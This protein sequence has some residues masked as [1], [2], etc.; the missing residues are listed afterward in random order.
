MLLSADNSQS[1]SPATSWRWPS[2]WPTLLQAAP[3]LLVV[4]CAVLARNAHPYWIHAAFAI[5]TVWLWWAG[6]DT[7]AN[8]NN[9]LHRSERHTRRIL[10]VV[11]I[12]GLWLGI[13]VW[14]V[15]TYVLGQ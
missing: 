1:V 5:V 4:G 10:Q 11:V 6:V 8:P 12:F 7:I 3:V 9:P 15:H 14:H 2:Q 13:A